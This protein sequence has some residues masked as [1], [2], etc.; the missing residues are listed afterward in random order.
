[1]LGVE[2]SL[3]SQY[4]KVV[5]KHLVALRKSAKL[6]QRQLAKLLRLVPS[7]IAHIEIGQRR[8]D[9][10]E[11]RQIVKACHGN[12]ES[13]LRGVVREFSQIERAKS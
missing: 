8:V 11:L 9:L 12:L 6:S 2:K 10:P 3:G 5:A 7:S 13:F 1:M 4:H